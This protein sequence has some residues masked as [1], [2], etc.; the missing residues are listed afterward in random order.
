MI[1]NFGLRL[2]A[3]GMVKYFSGVVRYSLINISKLEGIKLSKAL[4]P[5]T[6]LMKNSFFCLFVMVN[7][8]R[9]APFVAVYEAGTAATPFAAGLAAVMVI[10]LL[11]SS[12]QASFMSSSKPKKRD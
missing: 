9:P 11:R 4:N 8:R 6:R 7:K 10:H 1:L 12:S 3:V 2:E 5:P